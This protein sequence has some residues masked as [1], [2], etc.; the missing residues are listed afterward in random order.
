MGDAKT[1]ADTLASISRMSAYFE[2]NEFQTADLVALETRLGR[3]ENLFKKFCDERDKCVAQTVDSDQ[4]AVDAN[5]DVISNAEDLYLELKAK[6]VRKINSLTNPSPTIPAGVQPTPPGSPQVNRSAPNSSAVGLHSTVSASPTPPTGHSA[7]QTIPK[8]SGVDGDWLTFRDSFRQLVHNNDRFYPLAK[9]NALASH[10]TGEALTHLEGL[11]RTDEYYPIAWDIILKEYD[12]P[13]KIS[14]SLLST[15]AKLKPVPSDSS[16]PSLRYVLSKFRTVTRQ[17]QAL[18]TNLEAYDQ[19]FVFQLTSLL[20]TNTRC[21]WELGR[22]KRTSSKLPDLFQFLDDRVKG[23]AKA[24]QNQSSRHTA[25]SSQSSYNQSSRPTTSAHQSQIKSVVVK[26]V[27]QVSGASDTCRFCKLSVHNLD[28]CE[29]FINLNPYPR[30][31]KVKTL[32]VC[33]GCLSDQHFLEAC[34]SLPCLHCNTGKK[35]HPLLCFVYC[36]N[37][38]KKEKGLVCAAVLLESDYEEIEIDEDEEALLGTAMVLVKTASGDLLPARALMDGGSQANLISEHC[39]QRL[40][41]PRSAR[42]VSVSPVGNSNR[43]DARGIV[44]LV[45]IPH[46]TNRH[47]QLTVSALIM[48]R[49]ASVMPGDP[50]DIGD[51]PE[52][53]L[54]DLA[55]PAL[56]KS[57]KIDI[58]LGANVWSRIVMASLH[59]SQ[60]TNLV[61][62]LTRFGWVVFGGLQN[63]DNGNFVGMVELHAPRNDKLNQMLQRFWKMDELPKRHH[64]SPEEE[65]CEKIFVEGYERTE[66]GRFCVPIPIQ[67][68]AVPLGES[69]KR[70]LRTLRSMEAK[71]ARKPEFHRKY[72][73]FMRKLIDKGI[74]DPFTDVNENAPHYFLLHHGIESKKKK[75]RTVFNGSAPTSSDESFND[76][77]MKGEKFQDNLVDI[78]LR[79]RTHRIALVG[80]IEQMYPQ[81]LVKEEF[82][83]MQL[84]LWREDTNQPI[85]TYCLT[86]VMFGMRYALHS[87]VRALQQGAIEA[88]HDYPNAS[89]VARRDFYVDDCMTGGDSA[90]E[91]IDLRAQLQEMLQKSGFPIKKWSSNSFSVMSSIPDSDW[92]S[93]TLFEDS[94][95]E[96]NSVLGVG[97]DAML[98]KLQFFVDENAWAE[99][100]TK[101]TVT[102]DVARL[103]RWLIFRET[104]K[105]VELVSVPRWMGSVSNTELELHGFCDASGLAYAAS[106]YYKVKD[107][108]RGIRCGLLTS[109]S[110][111]APV[112]SVSIPRLELCGALLVAQLMKSVHKALGDRHITTHFWCDSQ[113]VLHWIHKAPCLFKEFVANRVS[114]VQAITLSIRAVWH[115]V[116]GECYPAD[117]ASRGCDAANI[118]NFDLWWN[119]PKWLP[120]SIF[121]WPAQPASLPAALQPAMQHEQKGATVAAVTPLSQILEA[122]LLNPVTRGEIAGAENFWILQT[123]ASAYAEELQ[124]LANRTELNKKSKLA[125]LCPFLDFDGIIRVGGRLQSANASYDE[126]HPVILPGNSTFVQMLIRR[127]HITLMHGGAQLVT[128][129]LRQKYWF[130][131]GRNAIR[132]TIFDCIVCKTHRKENGGQQMAPLVQSRVNIVERPFTDISIDYAGPFELK[133]WSGR[134]KTMNKLDRVLDVW[135]RSAQA[136]ILASRG[137]DWHFIMPRSPSQ[138]GSHE[139]AVKLFKHHLKRVI[140]VQKL[141]VF[142]FQSI[143]TK[144]EGCLNSRP[145]GILN[146]DADDELALTPAHFLAG[147]SFESVPT[148]LPITENGT[149]ATKWRQLQ[150]IQQLFWKRWQTDYI[151]SLQV[152]N[153]WLNPKE[154]IQINDIVVVCEDNMPPAQWRLGRITATHPGADGLVRNLTI[155]TATGSIKRAIQRVCKLLTPEETIGLKD[156]APPQDVAA[157]DN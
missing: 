139:V 13:Q 36:D 147:S 89:A 146:E 31:Q 32:K 116:P 126:K 20:D 152:R 12:D 156:S 44:R 106:I 7:A 60:N 37:Q 19:M 119:G 84:V 115:Y 132:S 109:K 101:R 143:I 25:P 14:D 61:A 110:R 41:L 133:R 24:M 18:G 78:L 66:S 26:K 151:N 72:V 42:N 34:P 53:V 17:L 118:I 154:N 155:H 142:E 67:P 124:Y 103:N 21:A 28:Q 131:G 29:K 150:Q 23:L 99:R 140:G 69:K 107:P 157:S 40:G 71:F 97:W 149:L 35:H 76:I 3:L 81:V 38:K 102:S 11:P 144:I 55:D 98:D 56:H 83:Q 117:I 138:G 48:G 27:N 68:N 59:A 79:F 137:I 63:P 86:R 120:L 122:L 145:L 130:I 114:E 111:V 77:Q 10:L 70:A 54:Q 2:S 47:F 112:Q 95:T 30:S 80:D 52:H 45:M 129:C 5:R 123:Q 108:S 104:L 1:R 50:I 4:A 134:C 125:K 135:N 46:N 9:F 128:R 148:D 15:L 127:A 136:S 57:G 33:F 121:D 74:M 75:H 94:E 22:S 93:K 16:L 100:V 73:E 62:Q 65:M 82:H 96:E 87:A 153:K 105:K 39:M 51:L 90:E 113:I 91:V 92:C 8:F 58:L 64:R 88:A 43:L 6:F 85:V 141:S 49:V